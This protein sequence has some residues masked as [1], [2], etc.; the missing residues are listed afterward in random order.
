[1]LILFFMLL[2]NTFLL[3]SLAADPSV[4]INPS[5]APDLRNRMPLVRMENG[6]KKTKQVQ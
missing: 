3:R 5:L 2:W 4:G 6:C 1:M